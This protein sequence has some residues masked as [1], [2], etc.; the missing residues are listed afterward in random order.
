MK[1]NLNEDALRYHSEGTPGKIEVVSTK[2]T[3]SER[4]LSLAYSPGVAAPCTEIAKDPSKVFDYTSK[5]NLVAV[6]TNG[7][8]VLGLGNIGPLAGK[9]VMEGKGVLF[10]QFAGIN[11][12]DIE[13]KCEDTDS[14]ISACKA[15]EPTFG[16]I[17]LEDIKAPDCFIIEETLKGEMNIPVFHD[18]QH[19]TA[20]IT[21]AAFMNAVEIAGKTLD[22]VK[23]VY[24]GAGAASIACARL[25]K[26]LGVP[27]ENICMCDSRGVI[28]RGRADGMNKYKEE[29]A[30]DTEDRTLADALKDSDVFVGLSV[31]GAVTPEMVLSMNEKPIVFAM[32][33]PDPEILPPDAKK[34]RADV[35]MATGRTDFPNQVNNVLGFPS[36]F[37]GALDVRATD[38]NEEMK[39]AAVKALAELAREDVP[40]SVSAAYKDESFSF[41][42]EYIIPKP[43][44]QRVLTK[45]APAVA[46]A[47]M[48]SGVATQPIKD[49]KAYKESLESLQGKRR[50]F[51]RSQ[52]N[53]VIAHSESK[54]K[55]LPKIVFP[56]GR[57][58]K[59][60]KALNTIVLE[61]VIEP[62]L[63]GYEDMIRRKIAEL[64]LDNLD[65]VQV[66]HPSKAEH[67]ESYM[68]AYYEARQRKGVLRAEA[69]RLMAD[70][71]YFGTMMLRQGH[72]S[73]LVTG[74][75][76]NYPDCIRPILEII[77]TGRNHTASGLNMVMIDDRFLFFADTTVNIDPTAEQIS[78][79]AIHASQVAKHFGITPKI[80]MLSFSNFTGRQDNPRKMKEA[81]RLV[82]ERHPELMVDGEMQADTAVNA[83]IMERIFPFSE[84]KGGA[85][86]LIF[87]NLDSGNMAYKLLQQLGGGEVMGPFLMGI[88]K[89]ANILQR[90]C[91]VE[92]VI[93]T[94]VLTAVEAQVYE[95]NQG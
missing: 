4:D 84:L 93:N 12:F 6:V 34:A 69:E 70:P 64:E 35:I 21:A 15:L 38:I 57:S 18:D 25:F 5:G 90:T 14:F 19:G 36:I 92:D 45:V 85:N 37:R 79:I 43:F 22:S 23:V 72:A 44:D 71:N 91:T 3:D 11:V 24:N 87:P 42:P 39:L 82:K 55:P 80:A 33:N 20:I 32:A 51:I 58:S 53:K 62:V 49:F 41:G 61:N 9:P 28:Y 73:G 27:G 50:G 94:I 60:L 10:K 77:G 30:I 68:N 65:N 29:F 7:S 13:L 17:N 83:D 46:Q 74:A 16:G 40:D 78:S 95:E 67:Y 89:P 81:A 8:A 66:I 47:A 59:I 63:I 31:A 48:D 54:K 86:I 56:E 75:T 26:S 76:Q 2:P 88:K 1:K 52:I